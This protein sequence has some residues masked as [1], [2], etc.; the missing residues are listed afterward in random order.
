MID[1]AKTV[2][3]VATQEFP[4]ADRSLNVGDDFMAS[5]E[6]ARMLK[7]FGKAEDAKPK[8]GMEA[9]S[10]VVGD[11][12]DGLFQGGAENRTKRKYNRRDMQA[13]DT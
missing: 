7:G 5:A 1:D 3:L 9:R 6:D 10:Q 13:Q 2:P 8:R 4:Y 12:G 11:S